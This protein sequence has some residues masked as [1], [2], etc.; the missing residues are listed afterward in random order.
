M[1]LEPTSAAPWARA[2]IAEEA[3]R[4]RAKMVAMRKKASGYAVAR[5]P[6][7][8]VADALEEAAI[9]LEKKLAAINPNT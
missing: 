3:I 5:P 6:A 1:T 8:Y 4:L 9:L 7:N 2:E